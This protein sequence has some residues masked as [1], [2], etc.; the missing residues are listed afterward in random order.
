MKEICKRKN[1]P[2]TRARSDWN[3]KRITTE[4]RTATECFVTM[5]QASIPNF[6]EKCRALSVERIRPVE[7]GSMLRLSFRYARCAAQCVRANETKRLNREEWPI[8]ADR[9]TGRSCRLRHFRSLTAVTDWNGVCSLLT[10]TRATFV[11]YVDVVCWP[12]RPYSTHDTN[13]QKP[14][15]F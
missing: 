14:H 6:V 15:W 2:C 1:V 11:L 13:E 9:F 10:F 8:D 12:L 3:C 4:I 5:A 7:R